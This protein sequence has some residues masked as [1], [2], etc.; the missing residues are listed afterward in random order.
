MKALN[1]LISA[2]AILIITPPSAHAAHYTG[3]AGA[4][5]Y[6]ELDTETGILRIYG[7]G[8]TYN[9]HGSWTYYGSYTE[10][11]A[12]GNGV[13]GKG[14]A[15]TQYT[16]NSPIYS[17]RN[18]VKTVI[19]EEGITSI[20]AAFFY[21]CTNLTSVTMP[22]SLKLI[23]YEAFRGCASLETIEIGAGV[24][25][26]MGRW[27]TECTKFNYISVAAGNSNYTSIGGVLY[28]SDLRILVCF[29]EAL[30]TIEYVIP[31]GTVYAA[32]DA[33][34][35]LRLVQSITI[36]TT[37]VDI[38]YGSFDQ[39]PNL[40]TLVLKSSTPPTLHKNMEG[41][42]LTGIYV[43]C[44]ES[45]TYSNS[46][47]WSSYSG[48]HIN[49]AVVVEFYVET[50]NVELGDVAIT[51]RADC[52]GYEMTIQAQPT[53]F[54]TF[55]HWTDGSTDAT[56]VIAINP[57]DMS[58]IYRY[59][60]IFDPKPYT[61]TLEKKTTKLGT[62][63]VKSRYQ[64]SATDGSTTIA[65]TG[66]NTTVNGTF[67]YGDTLT[68]YVDI[69]GTGLKFRRWNGSITD[70][71]RI[72]VVKETDSYTG[73]IT[74][75][76]EI[77][78]GN[79]TIKTASN[80]N[81]YGTTTP[82][83]PQSVSF[84]TDVTITATPNANYQL[85]Y[86]DDE[87][88]NTSPE[89]SR[90]ITATTDKT[91]K[92]YFGLKTYKITATPNDAE[93]GACG[94]Y[95]TFQHGKTTT[96]TATPNT[97]YEFVRWNDGNT[98][99][100]RSITVTAA[101]DYVAIFQPIKYT[102]NFYNDGGTLLETKEVDYNTLPTYT[103]STPTKASTAQYAYTHNGWTPAIATV[104]GTANYT[105]TYSSTLRSYTITFKNYDGT[106]LATPTVNY[107]ATPT[108]SGST[109]T[110]AADVQ[111]TY[112]HNGW[113]PTITS[114]TG[115]ATYTATFS[116][117]TNKYAIRFL[118]GGNVIQNS[119]WDY[120][121]TPSYTGATPTKSATAEWTYTF[122]G[123][124]QEI[125][126]VTGAKDYSATF[127]QTKNKYT[128][129]FKNDDGTTLQTSELEYGS[130]PSYTGATPTKAA[131]AEWSYTFKG[132]DQEI[133]T[134]T[135]A[136]TYTATYTATKN[137]YAITF[138]NY[139]GTQLQKT[140]VEYG[141]IPTYSGA[142][143]TKPA[144]A[145]YTYTF[146]GWDT[147]L[148]AVTGEKTY[149]AQFSTSDV[150]YTITFNNYDGSLIT[151][152]QYTHNAMP[153]YTGTPARAADAQ[154]TYTF[155]G[156][157]PA[158][159][160]VTA[161]ATYTATYSTTTNKYT[162]SFI[163]DDN[164][165]LK[166]LENVAYGT[167]PSYGAN[168]TKASTAQ[169]TYTFAGWTPAITNVTSNAT[170]KATYNST[171]RQYTITYIDGNGSS[172][173][174]TLNYNEMPTPPANPAKT[175]TAKYTYTFS[176]WDKPIVAVS[177]N[178][179]YTAQFS[180]TINKYTIRFVNYN[181]D[182]LQNT[183]V[184]YGTTPSE[185]SAPS[186]PSDAQYS[187]SFKGWDSE[188][189]AVTE[190]KTYKA[191]YNNNLRSYD[192]HFVNDDNTPLET[193]TVEYGKTPAYSGSTPTKLPT[194]QYT[195]THSGWTPEIANVTG[196]A[197]YK[198]TYNR[199]L[200][201]YKVTFLNYNNDILQESN[202]T[203]GLHQ[204][205]NKET[206]TRTG[207]AKYRYEFKG[208]S[209]AITNETTVTGAQTYT[210][211]FNEI[212]NTYTIT[213]VNYDDEP[214]YSSDF[215]Y[216]EMP[217]YGGETP[218]KP[219]DAEHTY[220]FISWT[221]AIATVTGAATYK[222]QFST[223][224]T[225]YDITF[226]DYDGSILKSEKYEYGQTPT[227]ATPI[228]PQDDQYIYTFTG[229]TPAI[230]NV[231][232]DAEYTASYSSTVRQY[233]IT[234]VD[235]NGASQKVKVNYGEVP[236]APSTPTKT[237][238][239]EFTYTFSGWQPDIATVT[240]E[241][242]YTAQFTPV[243]QKYTITFVDYD[244]SEI[245]SSLLPHG[246]TPS[247]TAPT[248][249]ADL[250]YSYT[251]R[252]WT[253][254][255]APV[256]GT[257]TYKATYNATP[258]EYLI[259][260]TSADNTQGTT[261]GSGE[262]QYNAEATIKATPQIGYHFEKWNDEVTTNPRIVTVTSNAEYTALFAPNTNTEYTLNIYTQNIEN[263][264]YQLETRTMT[265]TT[266]QLSAYEAPARTGFS[267]QDF[268]QTI[269]NG[270]GSSSISVYYNR[271]SYT[272]T[273]NTNGGGELTGTYTSGSVKYDSEIT[274]PTNPERAGFTFSGWL[275]SSAKMPAEDV[276]CI[277]QWTEKGDTPYAIE[278]YQ[279]QLDGT[280]Q[281]FETDNTQTGK[282]N[283]QTSVAPIVYS[284][285]TFDHKTDCNIEADGSSVAKIYYTRNSYN[286]KWIVDG[287][288]VTEG[289]THGPVLF[290]APVTQPANPEKEG[291]SF[292]NWTQEIATTMPASNIEYVATWTTD[293]ASYIVAHY[294]QNT[295][296]VYPVIPTYAD[297]LKG[298]TGESTAAVSSIFEGFT[299]NNFEQSAIAANG[300]TT[301]NIF[302]QRNSYT[303]TWNVDGATIE[304]AEYT[305]GGQVIFGKPIIAPVLEKMGYTHTWDT[306]PLTM[307]AANITCTA[308]WTASNN[309]YFVHHRQ[310]CLNGEYSVVSESESLLGLTGALTQ[311][312]AKEYEGFTVTEFTQD[313][314]SA[315]NI[316]T[317]DIL[318]SRNSYELKWDLN[319]GTAQTDSC[320]IGTTLFGAP[321]VAPQ[322]PE[323]QGYIF[324]GWDID[325][326]ETMPAENLTLTAIW[327][328]SDSTAYYVEHYAQNT[329][330]SYPDAPFQI[331]SLTGTTGNNIS[332]TD[333]S[334]FGF[335]VNNVETDTIAGDGS[336]VAKVY[337]SRNKYELKW[338]LNGGKAIDDNY[339]HAGMVMFGA[340][341]IAPELIYNNYAYIWDSLPTTMPNN[342]VTCTAIWTPIDIENYDIKFTAPATLSSCENNLTINITDI[343]PTN[344]TF[345]WTING[346]TDDSQTGP[347]FNIPDDAPIV[348][349]IYVT[350]I[351]GDTKLTKK[352]KYRINKRLITTMW[353]DV[354]VANNN[355]H[356]FEQ[357]QWYHNGEL[358]GN[359]AFYNEI[360]GLTGT[361]YLVATTSSGEE[362]CSCE[363]SFGNNTLQAISA[364]PNPTVNRITITSGR[365]NIGDR[366]N[367]TDRNGKLYMST[368]VSNTAGETIDLSQL[369]QGSYIITVGT[370]SVSIVKF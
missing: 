244:D 286:L 232:A 141:T 55:S 156:W 367:I 185:P 11:D 172:T 173:T 102:I 58:I 290:G 358:V 337:Y 104:T 354:V 135:G 344:I 234:F 334:P 53:S 100:S 36:P 169:Y 218:E 255:L 144:D 206:P 203:Y 81:T 210:A 278:H 238:T 153:S 256:T 223:A 364:F 111:Y 214:L 60:A 68:L 59:K 352:I 151:T 152:K 216:D 320:T 49:N 182:E 197:T 187:Y 245:Q 273:W 279:Q 42:S 99:A 116:T 236:T 215:K 208:W 264:D 341:I 366:I 249:T 56:R 186:K 108:Y 52:D 221:P 195:Y 359:K 281:L 161:N 316:T 134:V 356:I 14:V 107:G 329:D 124:D 190:A 89:L 252:S 115:A 54:G 194:V 327:K 162:I 164:S 250:Q 201:Q 318:Y 265:G 32:T 101:A 246:E 262:Y 193:Y 65:T 363:E 130:T 192:I 188:I 33:L 1:L 302:Y 311:A 80:D 15:S 7:T 90:T 323:K 3:N 38:E 202:I 324:N 224:A 204:S 287:T 19:I 257:A 357:Y 304:T 30:N 25:K 227:C 285:F 267:L 370:E 110:R 260:A 44:G 123:W 67:Y 28:T 125:T 87:P 157:S 222:A 342:N 12:T 180:S 326:P 66:S 291:Y 177:G 271:N 179:T 196:E 332:A 138:K 309:V 94:G 346:E 85:M 175:A 82:T 97:G 225:L 217:S 288:E 72:V 235:G 34:Y 92:A 191:T 168:P 313:T 61:I 328:A 219:S 74:Y 91:Y 13:D 86:W 312:E 145:D 355:D 280:Y 127:N 270:D 137:K 296:S 93:M 351:N 254:T 118:N 294:L 149:I 16:G 17:N 78:T 24:E 6:Y 331:D 5:A 239:D 88:D 71:P 322:M 139:N 146:S 70:N 269:I 64:I 126:T 307:P 41:T 321:V 129:L 143:P 181:N 165:E 8:E 150:L 155:N 369:P 261:S 299:A 248:R 76:A 301:I 171:I 37:M 96:L 140:D 20:G 109:P 272:L 213:F 305:E 47:N 230:A 184:E 266:N 205:Y 247:C 128:I 45:A 300:S 142:T 361:Y 98:N 263:D 189:T 314:I 167:T 276:E 105:A 113:S 69:T 297:T 178:A 240:G 345:K 295:N 268:E 159:A 158:L 347:T 27:A 46:G 22:N 57:D 228:R 63:N 317:I 136:K 336:S 29:P 319:G 360:G 298:I 284:G 362:I 132:W 274:A 242:T 209:P 62:T 253:P 348:G 112:T 231:T 21:Q 233:D 2:I 310:Q 198:A 340:E 338:E 73:S 330:G 365:W 83:T 353:D 4:N 40:K 35:H 154:Y 199:S 229:W 103:G 243:K 39:C 258:I 117:T 148:V 48:G 277:A 293:S 306:L 18:Y 349:T 119:N 84:G 160:A 220:T 303:L 95:G 50:N 335:S 226:K 133:A 114:V 289:C 163:D 292:N 77:T 131:T 75:S 241:A 121:T 282:T 79:V 31:E 51:S 120:G 315:Q 200:Q 23:N 339:T 9:R 176:G 350:G 259:L 170:Y 275:N 368:I 174:E 166:K 10:Y 43:P 308:I 183:D 325:I 211:Q 122:K 237:A 283:T 251:F 26:I 106:T 333:R 207:T 147:D 343:E 212:T